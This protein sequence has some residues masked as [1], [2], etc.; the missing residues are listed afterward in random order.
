MVD[1]AQVT[2]WFWPYDIF[3]Y[4]LPGFIVL[5]GYGYGN[6]KVHDIVQ[7]LWASQSLMS[8]VL[9]IGLAYV[10]GHV[11][12]ALSSLCLERIFLRNIMR[13]PTEQMFP[14][15]MSCDRHFPTAIGKIRQGVRFVAPSYF[16]PYSS[17][18]QERV[19][20][21]FYAVYTVRP[22]NTHDLFWQAFVH[23][24]NCHPALYR[25]FMHFVELY[26]FARNTCMSF[27]LLLLAPLLPFWP[28]PLPEWAWALTSTVT[29]GV[30]FL[31]Y[32]RLMRRQNDE[33]Y[34]CFA[35]DPGTQ[36]GLQPERLESRASG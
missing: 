3:G 8:M 2:G 6:Q 1:R 23:E 26:G 7:P 11:V 29:A 16:R 30:L 5:A 10:L 32:A 27:L 36:G 31:D 17:E 4:L 12:S 25:R 34:R 15:L 21:R 28:A 33:V 20:Q 35:L 24:A 19:L 9:L 13:Y 14:Y 18:F 22:T